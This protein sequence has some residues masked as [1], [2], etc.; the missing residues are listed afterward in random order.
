MIRN[1]YCFVDVRDDDDESLAVEQAADDRHVR[2][3]SLHQAGGMSPLR[4]FSISS[5]SL[6]RFYLPLFLCLAAFVP[7]GPVPRSL[8]NQSQNE[9]QQDADRIDSCYRR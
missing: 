7:L 6:V 4:S 2:Y 9:Q 8:P 5:L 1:L 3:R